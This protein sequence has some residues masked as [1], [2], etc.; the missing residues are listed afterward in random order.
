MSCEDSEITRAT[1]AV[2]GQ[3]CSADA[4]DLTLPLSTWLRTAAGCTDV[5]EGCNEGA[6][7]ACMVIMDGVATNS[8]LVPVA[9]CDGA[10]VTTVRAA[11]SSSEGALVARAFADADSAQCGF[12]I[13][14]M[15]CSTVAALAGSRATPPPVR[16]DLPD[17]R[18]G[19][20]AQ[21]VLDAH[22]CRCGGYARHQQ[23][24]STALAAS[25]DSADSE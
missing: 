19:S 2:N 1:F 22:L 24:I 18:H 11:L 23:A 4:D 6:C 20:D 5:K 16:T 9:L 14:G 21:L 25:P 3:P 17:A 13:G 8:C 10:E 15:I 7:G 12:C